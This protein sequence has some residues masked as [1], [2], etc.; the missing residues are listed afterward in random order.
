MR[1]ETYYRPRDSQSFFDYGTECFGI[2]DVSRARCLRRYIAWIEAHLESVNV[3]KRMLHYSSYPEGQDRPFQYAIRNIQVGVVTNS[4]HI[5]IPLADWDGESAAIPAIYGE[6]WEMTRKVHVASV[7]VEGETYTKTVFEEV[8]APKLR[9]G[10]VEV[11]INV[12]DI[13][14]IVLN[15][16]EE[17]DA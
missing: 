17:T 10:K 3:A 2:V 7:E 4:Q 16:R 12:L 13:E 15:I 14:T 1:R 11:E 9:D 8:W 5:P 6:V